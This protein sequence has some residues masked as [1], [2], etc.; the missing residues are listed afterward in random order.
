MQDALQ[1][2]AVAAKNAAPCIGA[3]PDVRAGEAR[4]L[5]A[6]RGCAICR[7]LLGALAAEVIDYLG[8]GGPIRVIGGLEIRVCGPPSAAWDREKFVSGKDIQKAV[9]SLVLADAGGRI[10]LLQSGPAGKLAWV[11]GTTGRA[12]PL[13]SIERPGGLSDGQGLRCHSSDLDLE[14]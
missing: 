2:A 10:R 12:V 1:V 4:L 5:V 14:L 11:R 13:P 7:L 6:D 8:A 9:R 3:I